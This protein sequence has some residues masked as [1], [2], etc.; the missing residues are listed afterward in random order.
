M[1]GV[2]ADIGQNGAGDA[3]ARHHVRVGALCG[4]DVALVDLVQL[5]GGAQELDHALA[6]PARS[7]VAFQ[8]QLSV[9]QGLGV[10]FLAAHE[11]GVRVAVE[12]V[13]PAGLG[14]GLDKPQT[15]GGV[16]AELGVHDHAAVGL[17]DAAHASG[18]L[19][20]LGQGKG[21]A[22]DLVL[23]HG[24]VLGAAQVLVVDDLLV[25]AAH[26]A[27]HDLR[28]VVALEDVELVR[29]DHAA[30]NGLA[31]PV[32]GVDGN[33]VVPVR[34]AAAGGR[35]G[36]KR[37]A[38]NQRVDHAH[39][40]HRERGVLDGPFLL[41]R[42]GDGIVAG[43]L[44]LVHGVQNGLAAIGH[45]A[46]VV[47]AGAVPVVG[48]D[49]AVLAHDV[50]VG[51]LQTGKGLLA[52]V[53]PGCGGAH[54]HG[55]VFQPGVVADVQV[56]PADGLHDLLRRLNGEDGR[57]HEHGALAQLVDALRAGGEALDH[58]VHKGPQ[59]DERAGVL[60]HLAGDALGDA[61][62]ELA[63]KLDVAVDLVVVPVGGV[64]FL[65]HD[66]AHQGRVDLGFVEQEVEGVG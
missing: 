50:Q 52:A 31:Q 54:G 62:G 43:L 3:H 13:V 34:A 5:K 56:G 55:L 6:G 21:P 24:H 38:G 33:Q 40:A 30:H 20:G 8:D 10:N 27:H 26:V 61:A 48:L 42:L 47:G 11:D 32:A 17:G 19:L 1:A 28:A 45:A 66:G 63:Q 49:A 41:G 23:V 46:Q 29:G 2:A 12:V 37:R 64:V 57:L 51:V 16:D 15:V 44:G 58:V 4:Q 39:D 35:V 36:G 59:L 14:P 65:V 25:L 9:G 60:G 18:D 53:F 7:A 22:E